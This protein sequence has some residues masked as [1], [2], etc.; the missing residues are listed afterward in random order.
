MQRF[1]RFVR[2]FTWRTPRLWNEQRAAIVTRSPVLAA[3]NEAA[4]AEQAAWVASLPDDVRALLD[5]KP[6]HEINFIRDG[7]A[8]TPPS[9]HA[10]AVRRW[11]TL[12]DFPPEPGPTMTIAER[13]DHLFV[14]QLRPDGQQY[15]YQELA[16]AFD[17]QLDPDEVAQL[18]AGTIPND[19]ISLRTIF[20]ISRFFY[21]SPQYFY[22]VVHI[23]TLSGPLSVHTRRMYEEMIMAVLRQPVAPGPDLPPGPVPWSSQARVL[24]DLPVFR[25]LTII[26]TKNRNTG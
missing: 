8:L 6:A 11:I 18:R 19:Q 14:T 26:G 13:V 21:V 7:A 20:Q 25:P 22:P 5:G 15:T 3:Y 17:S 23:R 12:P 24:S 10:N 1:Q 4:A 2:R 16:D 9:D